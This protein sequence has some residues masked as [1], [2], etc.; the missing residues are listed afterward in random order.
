MVA[1]GRKDGGLSGGHNK[2]PE[3]LREGRPRTA[4]PKNLPEVYLLPYPQPGPPELHEKLLRLKCPPHFIG[5]DREVLWTKLQM[6]CGGHHVDIGRVET[7]LELAA[8]SWADHRRMKEQIRQ[9]GD[10]IRDHNG[11]LRRHPLATPCHQAFQRLIAATKAL[12]LTAHAATTIY[13][14]GAKPVNWTAEV[15]RLYEDPSDE[16]IGRLQ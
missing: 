6:T 8:D 2:K 4:R 15:M 13:E 5:D 3:H 16:D 14:T 10:L 11:L 9:D 12:G 1:K 7:L